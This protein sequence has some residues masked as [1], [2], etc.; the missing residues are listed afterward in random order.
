MLLCSSIFEHETA[1]SM[2]TILKHYVVPVMPPPPLTHTL[3]GC[4]LK[5]TQESIL[6][7]IYRKV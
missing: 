4:F 6:H 2:I 5:K 1:A 3:Q 7:T